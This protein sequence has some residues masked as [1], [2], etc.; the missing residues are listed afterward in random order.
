[1]KSKEQKKLCTSWNPLEKQSSIYGC[2]ITLF[3]TFITKMNSLQKNENYLK[4][5]IN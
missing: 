2:L 1:M 3:K 4:F 5:F